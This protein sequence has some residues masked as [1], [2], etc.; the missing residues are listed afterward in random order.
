ML[1][2]QRLR[3]CARAGS[4]ALVALGAACGNAH[5]PSRDHTLVVALAAEPTLLLPPLIAE[6]PGFVVADQILERLAEPDSTLDIAGDRAFHPRLADRWAWAPDSLSIAFHIAPNAR[7]HDGRPVTAHDVRFTFAIYTDTAVASPAASLLTNIDSVEVRNDRV[8][9]FWFRRRHAHQFFDATYHMRILPEHVLGAAPPGSLRSSAFA[10]APTGSGPFRFARWVPGQFV[11]LAANDAFREG[12]ARFDRIVFTIATDPSAA[13]ARTIAGDIDIMPDLAAADASLAARATSLRLVRW[14]S[15]SSGLVMLDLHDP[16]HR[17]RPHPVLDDPSVRQALAMAIDRAGL[18]AAALGDGAEPAKG[19]L[20]AA[21]LPDTSQLLPPF[22]PDAAAALLESHGWRLP[23]GSRVRHRGTTPLELALLVSISGAAAQRAAV[24]MQ[25]Q[26]SRI[27]ARLEIEPV[28]NATLA[29][30]LASHRFDAALIA[31]DWDPNP[32]SAR[33]LWGSPGD[34]SEQS[35]N[36]G[37]YRSEAFD[38]AMN[39]ASFA[40]DSTDARLA[41]TRAWRTLVHD[42]PAIW[43]YDFRRVAAIRDCIRPAAVRADSWWS[44]LA[45]WSVSH[46]CPTRPGRS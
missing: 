19:P 46:R 36:F 18:T 35:S 25:D 7:W 40:L 42:A 28:D 37:G 43:L 20:P 12:R 3:M 21:L 15:L 5:D 27:G 17:D 1:F 38:A 33:Q 32:L 31:L 8:A 24:V 41:A 14:P 45:A 6:T 13:L 11:E 9:V 30:R 2:A 22:D 39:A 34:A 4:C 26:L 44:S 16:V 29:T 23:H 10:R